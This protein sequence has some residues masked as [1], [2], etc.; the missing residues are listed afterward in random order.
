MAQTAQH[1]SGQDLSC[2]MIWLQAICL[3]TMILVNHCFVI[4][5]YCYHCILVYLYTSL[6]CLLY[7]TFFILLVMGLYALFFLS[8]TVP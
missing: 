2:P 4:S 1:L 5:V 8:K 3:F 7:N 6:L